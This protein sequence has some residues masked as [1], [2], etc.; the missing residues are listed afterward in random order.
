[1]RILFASRSW[2]KTERTGVPLVAAQ[3]VSILSD[4]GHKISIMGSNR[5]IYRED[6]PDVEKYYV[7]SQ[8]AGSFYSPA[9][10]DRLH[11]A[12][13]LSQAKPDLVICEAWQTAL[14][15]SAID[16]A[17]AM[18]VPIL[19]I[20]HGVSLHSHSN[21]Y[22]DRARASAWLYYRKYLLP[23]RMSKLSAIT[24]LDESAISERFYDRDLARKENIPLIPLRNAP[25]NWCFSNKD[26]FA[27]KKQV[28]LVG[29]FS[30]IKNQLGAIDVFVGLPSSDIELRFIG[31][32]TGS[33][34]RKCV[35]K[36]AKLGILARVTFIQ[37]DECDV[38]EE[39]S[40]SLLVLN[41]SLTEALPVTLVEAMASG[42]PFVAT[43]VGAIPAM[44]AGKTASSV[45][46]LQ[47][48]IKSLLHDPNY[49]QRESERGRRAYLTSYT[50]EDIRGSLL[51]AVL[52]AKRT[53]RKLA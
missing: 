15:D 8:G 9:I 36:V 1:M 17:Y 46:D 29:Y 2:P 33:Y 41:T 24:A 51:E 3:H 39:I 43:P 50:K 7:P 26:F 32:R 27:R 22:I 44:G 40:N 37:D 19:M 23:I 34:Y 53:G 13:V 12:R 6:V 31:P 4:A 42:T 30:A 14:T 10:V 52:V 11:L 35:R 49:W 48:L 25:V 21:R 16:V 38:A 45:Q 18:R 47:E 5:A 28:L 20:S